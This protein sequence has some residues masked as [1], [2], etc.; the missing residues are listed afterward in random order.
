MLVVLESYKNYNIG[1]MSYQLS[2]IGSGGDVEWVQGYSVYLM[3][4]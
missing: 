1:V 3:V 4:Y 2:G